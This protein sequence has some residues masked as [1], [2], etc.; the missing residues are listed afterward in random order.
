MRRPGAGGGGL[1]DGGWDEH[2]HHPARID[3]EL[4]RGWRRHVQEL[5]RHTDPC[6]FR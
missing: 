5:V 4:G 6:M 1:S 3:G 2:R